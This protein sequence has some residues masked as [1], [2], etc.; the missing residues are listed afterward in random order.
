M[1]WILRLASHPE[2][3]FARPPVIYG[4]VLSRVCRL[5]KFEAQFEERPVHLGNRIE[6][7]GRPSGIVYGLAFHKGQGDRFCGLRTNWTGPV[8]TVLDH[9]L[10]E[11]GGRFGRT[12]DP[13]QN[14]ATVLQSPITVARGS[15][16]FSATAAAFPTALETVNGVHRALALQRDPVSPPNKG[17]K[18][19]DTGS[20][21][22]FDYQ[23]YNPKPKRPRILAPSNDSA[24]TQVVARNLPS[25]SSGCSSRRSEPV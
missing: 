25:A 3:S 13:E 4:Q 17:N 21:N 9:A 22:P 8:A 15:P 20:K 23:S 19:N 5:G 10:C 2:N 1:A 6:R 18:D 14:L 12:Q 7:S 24:R 16:Q 11:F